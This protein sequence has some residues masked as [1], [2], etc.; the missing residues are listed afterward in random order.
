MQ[1]IFRQSS[2]KRLS[3]FPLPTF[4]GLPI[5]E[6]DLADDVVDVVYD[7]FD[8]DGGVCRASVLEEFGEG[9]FCPL[10]IGEAVGRNFFF[11]V[12]QVTGEVEQGFEEGDAVQLPRFVLFFESFEAFGEF[13]VERISHMLA[14]TVYYFD[15]QFFGFAV[16]VI[17]LE[18]GFEQ[19]GVEDDFV[20]IV[21][22]GDVGGDLVKAVE[23]HGQVWRA[24]YGGG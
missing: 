12:D 23:G 1:F 20:E 6:A 17:S 21:A 10:F 7:A 3:H 18:H 13:A 19:F 22:D 15:L 9:G 4:G 8:H 11:G 16:G 14:Q 5:G 24:G 2:P